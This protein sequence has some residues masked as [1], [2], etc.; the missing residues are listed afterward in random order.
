MWI[1]TKNKRYRYLISLTDVGWLDHPFPGV[2]ELCHFLLD[3]L[4]GWVNDLVHQLFCEKQWPQVAFCYGCCSFVWDSFGLGHDILGTK[5]A[6]RR[7]FSC[8]HQLSC[9][10]VAFSVPSYLHHVP[11]KPHVTVL[12]L[13][14]VPVPKKLNFIIPNHIGNVWDAVLGKLLFHWKGWQKLYKRI[15]IYGRYSIY[16]IGRPIG[17]VVFMTSP[18]T[19]LYR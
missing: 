2:A 7:A 12:S 17:T 6:G 18:L 14:N 11:K 1:K 16:C 10:S 15:I 13:C 4:V 5:L 3:L 8:P 19:V 9:S